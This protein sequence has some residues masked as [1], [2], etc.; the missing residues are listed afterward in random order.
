MLSMRRPDWLVICAILLCCA[1]W[2]SACQR[3]NRPHSVLLVVV[4]TLRADAVGAYGAHDG[5]T[6]KL[7]AFARRAVVFRRAYA[8]CS[9]THPSVA[10]LLTGQPPTTF[11][12]GA[13]RYMPDAVSTLAEVFRTRGY[14]TAAFVANPMMAP[15]LG[16]ERGFDSYRGY[17]PW[18]SG[19]VPLEDKVGARTVADEV[20]AWLEKHGRSGPWFLYVHF[21]D[22]HWPYQ[23]AL[24]A[25]RPFWKG[26]L[27]SPEAIRSINEQVRARQTTPALVAL[28]RNLYT[29][30]VAEADAEIGR[31]LDTLEGHGMMPRTVVAVTADHGEE[32]GDHGGV[33][34]ARTLYDEVL[35]VPLLLWAPGR[36]PAIVDRPVSHLSL[37]STLSE[38]AH[39]PPTSLPGPTL[40]QLPPPDQNPVRAQLFPFPPAIHHRAV[41]HGD[42]KLILTTNGTAELYDLAA[43]PQEKHNRA[44]LEPIQVEQLGRTPPLTSGRAHPPQLNDSQRERMRALGYDF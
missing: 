22:P 32:F 23:P 10:T 1:G 13:K 33:L 16:F 34:H 11:Q 41:I 39:L 42:Q 15:E 36:P 40:W 20:I 4:D 27:P 14:R 43:D 8:V 19:L 3:Q 5:A 26:D 25:L 21:M 24:P 6:P 31:I 44:A 38:A 29:A 17:G 2:N 9:W 18:V 35:R 12:P 37:A 7:D 28:A 30:S